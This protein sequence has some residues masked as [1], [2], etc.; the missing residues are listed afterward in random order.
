MSNYID[1]PQQEKY[2]SAIQL[3]ISVARQI[4][5]KIEITYHT[6]TQQQG[7]GGGE[8]ELKMKESG[9]DKRGVEN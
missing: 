4:K 9:R 7:W 8:H 2:R 6:T 3:S 5:K 1:R